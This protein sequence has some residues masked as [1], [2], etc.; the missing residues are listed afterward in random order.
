MP[1]KL[2]VWQ[3][4]NPYEISTC[5]ARFLIISILTWKWNCSSFSGTNVAR[6]KIGRV[7][8]DDICTLGELHCRLLEPFSVGQSTSSEQQRWT[9]RST[10]AQKRMRLVE[11]EM[12][13]EWAYLHN[14]WTIHA[15]HNW[16]T[17]HARLNRPHRSKL[18]WSNSLVLFFLQTTWETK[19]SNFWNYIVIQEYICRSEI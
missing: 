3:A 4:L 8:N 7:L 12:C 9:C 15:M 10:L 17:I 11:Y 1:A 2:E 5:D 19:I 14:W 18:F 16:W 13:H 6:L